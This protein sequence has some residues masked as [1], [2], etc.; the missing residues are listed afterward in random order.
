[1][2]RSTTTR[3]ETCRPW[4]RPR[5]PPPLTDPR[6]QGLKQSHIPGARDNGQRARSTTTRI[7]TRQ[8]TAGQRSPTVPL[9]D[10]RQQGLKQLRAPRNLMFCPSTSPSTT[11]RIETHEPLS[12]L[13]ILRETDPR[14]Q[15]L[16]RCLD[17]SVWPGPRVREPDPR[18]QG[19][20]RHG[21]GPIGLVGRQMTDD[22]RQQGLKHSTWTVSHAR[23]RLSETDDPRQQGLKHRCPDQRRRLSCQRARSTTT[24]IETIA[25]TPSRADVRDPIHD[26]KD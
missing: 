6:Q 2:T 20:K 3:I 9:T 5:L 22:P 18:Q 7:E 16:K 17:A 23:D 1:M 10:P 4:V 21:R 25:R 19:L 11:T 14:Q 13:R 15:G 24:R 26:N 8:R 12:T